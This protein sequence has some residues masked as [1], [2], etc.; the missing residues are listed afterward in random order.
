MGEE[1][2]QLPS[3]SASEHTDT[4]SVNGG[5]D[6]DGGG[7]ITGT[8]GSAQLL[9]EWL[10]K[11][12]DRRRGGIHGHGAAGRAEAAV[13]ADLPRTP[14][15]LPPPPHSL[16]ASSAA[17]SSRRTGSL[18]LS[19]PFGSASQKK[20]AQQQRQ[21]QL[22]QQQREA[23]VSALRA[24]LREMAA[25]LEAA[26][27]VRRLVTA[28]FAEGAGGAETRPRG[29]GTAALLAAAA[30]RTAF[31]SCCMFPS[32]CDS[33]GET[34]STAASTHAAAS[35]ESVDGGG[36]GGGRASSHWQAPSYSGACTSLDVGCNEAVAAAAQG[37]DG[38]VDTAMASL[39]AAL[40]VARVN[41]AVSVVKFHLDNEH[42]LRCASTAA[43]ATCATTSAATVAQLLR[44]FLLRV[45]SPAVRRASVLAG[46]A[47]LHFLQSRAPALHRQHPGLLPAF[48][49]LLLRIAAAA[50]R[51][52]GDAVVAL[53]PYM[54]TPRTA[55]RLTLG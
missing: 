31:D 53:L 34:S 51:E 50:P 1:E 28:S 21:Q 14:P 49:P 40:A 15:V 46:R 37:G 30:M 19:S 26:E 32:E 24:R 12:T 41:L 42:L 9:N 33:R 55:L 22:Q 5:G 3:P 7:G 29:A 2:P 20:R 52:C 27:G 11:L 18:M 8:E 4:V 54:H 45:V 6:D 13:D 43:A 36:G 17:S 35:I 44:D 23:A 25:R 48:H 38:P 39:E 16:L 10:E 47:T